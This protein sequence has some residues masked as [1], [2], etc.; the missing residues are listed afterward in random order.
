MRN[1][2][3]YIEENKNKITS[4]NKKKNTNEIMN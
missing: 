3:I 1:K 4:V 2:Q